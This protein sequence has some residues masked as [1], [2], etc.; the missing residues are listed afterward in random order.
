MPS[1][2]LGRRPWEPAARNAYA[3]QMPTFS[4]W[5]R[6]PRRSRRLWWYPVSIALA[7]NFNLCRPS[8][9]SCRTPDRPWVKE[10]QVGGE[11]SRPAAQGSRG[12]GCRLD[13]GDW[14][15]ED[16]PDRGQ[17]TQHAAIVAAVSAGS[18]G[19]T[20]NDSSI[21]CSLSAHWKSELTL[22]IG[23]KRIKIGPSMGRATD[24]T[25]HLSAGLTSQ[26]GPYICL[27][28]SLS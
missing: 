2:R 22:T 20:A 14:R 15:A 3:R 17:A 13:G 5:R 8:G 16:R 18:H 28:K 11:R 1:R 7:S 23:P 12:E 4:P 27:N 19:M 9:Q 26:R 21:S 6:S 10:T 24:S 25:G